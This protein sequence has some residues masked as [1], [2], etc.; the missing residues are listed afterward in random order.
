M[1][2]YGLVQEYM[3]LMRITSGVHCG[4]NLLECTPDG[5]RLGVF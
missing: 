3:G 5:I 2:L 4:K 1:F